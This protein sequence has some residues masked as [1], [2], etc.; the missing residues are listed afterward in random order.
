M[1]VRWYLFV[2]ILKL[3]LILRV[4]FLEGCRLFLGILANT[5]ALGL[6]CLILSS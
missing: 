3:I 6:G 1:A 2:L 4:R 5:I